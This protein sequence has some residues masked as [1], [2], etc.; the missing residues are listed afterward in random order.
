MD[1][2]WPHDDH[3]VNSGIP[4]DSYLGVM[5]KIVFPTIDMLCKRA[6]QLH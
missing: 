2:S 4:K 6:A 1:L 5:V 3:S